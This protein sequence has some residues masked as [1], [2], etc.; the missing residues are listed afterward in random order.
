M[1]AFLGL[2]GLIGD[3]ILVLLRSLADAR[4]LAAGAAEARADAAE[5]AR[6]DLAVADQARRDR[7]RADP[8]ASPGSLPD[9]GFR[10]D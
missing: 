1:R 5:K 2:I 4:L 3:I 7:L 8:D 9:D 10:R 6:R